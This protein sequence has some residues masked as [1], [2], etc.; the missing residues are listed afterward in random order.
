MPDR[1]G[2]SF[3]YRCRYKMNLGMSTDPVTLTLTLLIIQIWVQITR[4]G[5]IGPKPKMFSSLSEQHCAPGNSHQCTEPWLV[6]YFTTNGRH[7][8]MDWLKSRCMPVHE[9]G[10]DEEGFGRRL[11]IHNRWHNNSKR[12][13]ALDTTTLYF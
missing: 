4:P 13:I 6:E 11:W 9:E 8:T 7:I 3:G 1:S 5:W 10:F 12:K 2:P